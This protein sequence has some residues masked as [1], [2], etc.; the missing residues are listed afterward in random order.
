MKQTGRG[1][2]V[3]ALCKLEQEQGY[4]NIVLDRLLT[5]TRLS[6]ADAALATRLFYGVLERKLTLDY[7]LSPFCRKPFPK[8]DAAVRNI[9]RV[10]AY[11][12]YYMDK[13]PAS[14]A[15]HQAVSQCREM[16]ISSAGGFVN[17]VLRALLRNGTELPQRWP[18]GTAGLELQYSVPQPWIDLWIGQY[19]EETV[20]QYLQSLTQTPEQVL[21]VNTL[22]VSV[23]QVLDVLQQQGVP[24]T[25][26]PYLEACL[27]LPQGASA[28]QLASLHQNWYYYQDTASQ[29]DCAALQAQSGEKIADVCAA[30]GGKTLTVAQQM[31]NRG[32]IWAFDLYEHKCRT[33]QQRAAQYGADIVKVACRDARKP[34]EQQW[35]EAFDRVLCDAPCSGFGVIRR[36]PEIRYK[37]PKEFDDLAEQQLQILLRAADMVR[38]GGVLQYSTCT[39]REQENQQVVQRFL[40]QCPHFKPRLLPIEACFKQAG[41]EIS[42]SITLWPHLHGADGFFIAG[43]TKERSA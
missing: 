5:A 26:H 18:D 38:V 13:I 16:G 36:K 42:H 29:W 6:D 7:L 9:L 4:S 43:F 41:L 32:E 39:L 11:Q 37:D 12:I 17:G 23:Q 3:S 34:V 28:K 20:L 35:K 14:A 19:G 22:A 15:V 8:L 25:Q 40:Q 21:R 31:Q 2:A 1:A 27:V 33:L 30:P 10:A 24:C